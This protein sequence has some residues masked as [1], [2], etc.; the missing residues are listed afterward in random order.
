MEFTRLELDPGADLYGAR[1]IDRQSLGK[2]RGVVDVAGRPIVGK[3]QRLYVRAVEQIEE[4][5]AYLELRTLL[6]KPGNTEIF[7]GAEVHI[8]IAG[9][10]ERITPHVA[11]HSRGC[12]NREGSGI[13]AAVEETATIAGLAL[14]RGRNIGQDAV[15]AIRPVGTIGHG[16]GVARL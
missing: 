14:F 8:G 12:G 7:H 2:G 10:T 1:V 5:P 15:D 9:S 4:L 16:V 3:A 11:F 13:E 6:G